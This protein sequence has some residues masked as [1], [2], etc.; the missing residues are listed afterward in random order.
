MPGQRSEGE[1]RKLAALALAIS[2]LTAVA[3]LGTRN[4]YDDEVLSLPIITSTPQRIIHFANTADFH[5]AG[6]YL[7]AH[8]ALHLIPSFRW[9]NLVPAAV[10]YAGLAVFVLG[11]APLFR[12]REAWVAFLLLATLHPQLF[13][14]GT[15][16]RWYSWWTGIAL[17]TVVVALQPSRGDARL[18]PARCISIGLLLATL[19]YLNYVTLLFAPALAVATAVRYR[20]VTLQ[21]KVGA[22][23]LVAAAFLGASAPQLRTFAANQLGRSGSQRAGV[24][25]SFA[26]LTY[27]TLASEAYLP[28]HPLAI[29]C[30][31]TMAIV[32]GAGVLRSSAWRRLDIGQDSALSSIVALA[33]SFFLLVGMSG[34]GGRPRNGLLLI[35][36]F[37]V[38]FAI[39][40]DKLPARAQ[41]AALVVVA[42]WTVV[43]TGHIL[44]RTHL[45]KATMIDRPEQVVSF[46]AS[47]RPE[48]AI[49][50]TYDPLLAF[51][52]SHPAQPGT[53]LLS[54]FPPPIA[55][56]AALPSA[57][58]QTELYVVRSYIGGNAQWAARIASELDSAAR[59]IAGS[60]VTASFS[61]DPDA[62][63]KRALRR[64]PGLAEDLKSAARLPDY[65]YTVTAGAISPA[66]ISLLRA[67]TPDF[68]TP[69]Q[70]YGPVS[71]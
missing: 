51:S 68:C 5:P 30:A 39:A 14:W 19:L 38:V 29:V 55:Q 35:P 17:L 56:S 70:C 24:V 53:V 26:H 62:P 67:Q 25:S 12:R 63:R 71:P 60:H 45:A 13:V 48:C 40:A 66:A 16:Y 42:L 59:L 3:V 21:R 27:A 37:A 43:G 18:S 65:R 50:V 33:A 15:S 11:F 20:S 34:L 36:L 23:F 54:A 22:A 1:K 52:M 2:L 6:M 47:T 49:V 44:T 58:S 61:F 9:M 28:W 4:L 64:I 32:L 57:C 8:V 46:I 10:L 69:D 41:Q 31:V 7:L